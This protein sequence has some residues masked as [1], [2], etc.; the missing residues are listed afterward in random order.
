MKR[1]KELRLDFHVGCFGNFAH[2][3]TVC[4]SMCALSI[5]CAIQ[6]D[7]ALQMEVMEDL[8]ASD[9]NSVRIQ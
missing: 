5:S 2:E 7:K 4:R 1:E 8:M 3:D 9:F 6:K